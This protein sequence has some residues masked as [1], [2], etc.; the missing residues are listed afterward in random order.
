MD[1]SDL[2]KYHKNRKILSFP[3]ASLVFIVF[4]FVFLIAGRNHATLKGKS[5]AFVFMEAR[6]WF[7]S[8]TV[9]GASSVSIAI[10]SIS[11]GV[12]TTWK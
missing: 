4:F 12:V 5:G 3:M 10:K 6:S 2:Y 1:Q 9:L 11:Q 7:L 8:Q